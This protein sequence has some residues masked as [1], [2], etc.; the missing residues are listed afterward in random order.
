[1]DFL[2]AIVLGIIQGITE[3]FPVSSSGH[4]AI[5]Q[6]L[7]NVSPPLFFDVALHAGTLFAALWFF[8]KEIEPI[9]RAA[10]RF[11]FRSKHGRLAK[12]II[13][14]TIP[15]A[16][17]GI[18]F[19]DFFASLFTR[20]DFIGAALIASGAWLYA[21]HTAKPPHHKYAHE[22]SKRKAFAVGL[23][24]GVAVAPGISR[25]GA[26]IGAA[27]LLGVNAV[28]ATRYS[29]LAALPAIAGAALYEGWKI[30]TA[31]IA[32]DVLAASLVG[33][34]AAAIVGFFAMGWLLD[35]IK[36]RRLQLF[37]EYCVVAGALVL[38]LM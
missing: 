31:P 1:M 19:H 26:T 16:I 13:V 11:N 4:L 27:K 18:A 36:Q 7:L 15:T 30:S 12:L 35:W 29:F 17:V 5:A 24:Q 23:A 25:S 32:S 20:P 22:I 33:A 37:A 10:C 21:A 14:T 3:W 2:T 6:K 9:V 34:L 8:R 38:I 28:E